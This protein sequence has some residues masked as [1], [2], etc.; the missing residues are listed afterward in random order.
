M[1]SSRLKISIFRSLLWT[2]AL[3]LFRTTFFIFVSVITVIGIVISVVTIASPL[4][5]VVVISM[6]S[7]VIAVVRILTS[8][9]VSVLVLVIF[10]SVVRRW[11]I[12]FVRC[13]VGEVG[14]YVVKLLGTTVLL[15]RAI[16]LRMFSST[17]GTIYLQVFFF[18]RLSVIFS[19][20]PPTHI[21]FRVISIIIIIRLTCISILARLIIWSNQFRCIFQKHSFLLFL[22]FA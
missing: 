12:L 10:I 18:F 5:I 11:S 20:Y 4:I 14:S 17:Y 16:C 7:A 3:I 8:V 2:P 1:M 21:M 15:I 6:A 13:R 19:K 9:I 22:K